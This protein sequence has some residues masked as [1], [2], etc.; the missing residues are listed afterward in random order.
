MSRGDEVLRALVVILGIAAIVCMLLVS[1][2]S[3]T[4]GL[5][6]GGF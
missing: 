1:D 3:K 2:A 6:Y 5:V 4:P